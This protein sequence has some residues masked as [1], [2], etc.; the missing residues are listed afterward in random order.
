MSITINDLYRQLFGRSGTNKGTDIEMSEHG[1]VGG[2][3]SGQPFKFTD[4]PDQA[5]KLVT[6]GS[7][8]YIA[9][10]PVGSLETALV[11]KAMRLDTTAGLKAE[12][13]DGNSDYDNK[14]DDITNLD[15]S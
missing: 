5:I 7:Y 11:W 14:V 8:I 15:Y 3:S 6:S 4:T 1:R 10:A 9:Y 12:Y 2:V 13:C